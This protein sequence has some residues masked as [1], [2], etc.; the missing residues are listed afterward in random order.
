[1]RKFELLAEICDVVYYRCF[2]LGTKFRVVPNN[3]VS[4]GASEV[5]KGSKTF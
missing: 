5:N 1:M 2:L 4:T 3:K